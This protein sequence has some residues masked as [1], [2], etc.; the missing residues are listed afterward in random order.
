MFC[1]L[2][3]IVSV[4]CVAVGVSV[5]V[6]A[7]GI[8]QPQVYAQDSFF[9]ERR[10]D[11]RYAELALPKNVSLPYIIESL[12]NVCRQ[13]WLADSAFSSR[14]K[15]ELE[16]A[17]AARMQ[18]SDDSA[19]FALLVR[20]ILM[21]SGRGRQVLCIELINNILPYYQQKQQTDYPEITNYLCRLYIM[22]GAA[23]EE[24][25]FWRQALNIYRQ[26]MALIDSEGFVDA[27]PRRAKEYK[28]M[29]YNNMGTIYLKR[30]DYQT[31]S[32]FYRQAIAINTELHFA[33]ELFNNYN[34]MAEVELMQHNLPKALEYAF[35]AQQQV[36]LEQS[37]Y[38]YY[39]IQCNISQI[40]LMQGKL[41][42]AWEYMSDGLEYMRDNGYDMDYGYGCLFAAQLW[43]KKKDNAKARFYLQEAERVAKHMENRLLTVK[44]YNQF[45]NYYYDCGNA[46]EAY[47]YLK[48][49]SEINDSIRLMDDVKRLSDMELVYEVE[50]VLQENSLLGKEAELKDL[51]LRRQRLMIIMTI[52]LCA[53]VFCGA[54]WWVWSQRKRRMVEQRLA[55]HEARLKDRELKNMQQRQE[56]L[57]NELEIKNRELT[58]KVLKLLKNNEFIICLTEELKQ[59]LAELNPRDNAKKEHIRDMMMQ[60]RL[61]SNSNSDAEFKYYFEQVYNSFYENLLK[62]YPSLTSKDLRL[63]AFLRLGLSTKEIAVITFREVR[64]VESSRNRLRK[65]MNLPADTNLTEFFSRF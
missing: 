7:Y 33:K 12:Y 1:R 50:K 9:K 21:L 13:E 2:S 35:L 44:V 5:S 19:V 10:L 45:S 25:G 39:F 42:I 59:L 43:N 58:S 18:A 31:A 51:R 11:I 38:D 64:S 60:L 15:A 63:C 41:E 16:Q 49:S 47:N 53:M 62:A 40:Y 52:V 26:D 6:S 32:G 65:K 3:K 27:M 28:A 24:V 17:Y 55:E 48:K 61:Q 20:N 4:L 57:S 54:V 14:T 8:Q 56:D 29:L 37:P 30:N 23:Y 22:L 34:N 36:S 46:E